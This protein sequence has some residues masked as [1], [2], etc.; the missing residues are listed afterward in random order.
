MAGK[1]LII[2]GGVIAVV[3]GG[4]QAITALPLLGNQKLEALL[5]GIGPIVIYEAVMAVVLIVGGI[6][7]L[8]KCGTPSAGGGIRGFGIA[9]IALG[10]VDLIWT[11]SVLG[12]PD[13]MASGLGSLAVCAVAG[14][15]LIAGGAKL[16]RQS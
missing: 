8:V 6:V 14:G 7:A 3:R 13:G 12:G 10:V 1:G 5:P 16:A 15:L 4:I 2:A 9:I 11:M